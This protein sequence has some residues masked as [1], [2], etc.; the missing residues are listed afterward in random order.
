VR[1]SGATRP[2]AT[3]QTIG[4]GAE[5]CFEAAALAAAPY[6]ELLRSHQRRL[7]FSRRLPVGVVGVIAPFNAPVVLAVRAL[8]PALALGNAVVLKPDP[9][10]AV[11]G[12]S[13]RPGSPRGSCTSSPAGR[14][15]VPP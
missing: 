5:E 2:F 14:T 11:C 10:T 9:R 4:G 12:S 7:S 1:E 13:R 3:I 8:A 6:G 15:P